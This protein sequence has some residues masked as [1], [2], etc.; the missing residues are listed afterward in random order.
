MIIATSDAGA[1]M[2]P[3]S[4]REMQCPK[5]KVVEYRKVAKPNKEYMKA[6]KNQ[7]AGGNEG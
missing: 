5:T 1:S 2:V 7:L 6:L 4:W 3:I